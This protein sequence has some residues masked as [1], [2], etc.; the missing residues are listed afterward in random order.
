[1]A[2]VRRRGGLTPPEGIWDVYT[3]AAMLELRLL[4]CVV[5]Q[6]WK[7]IPG[8]KDTYHTKP[9]CLVSLPLDYLELDYCKLCWGWGQ[10]SRGLPGT[11]LIRT[12][13]RA[14]GEGCWALLS[15]QVFSF[16]VPISLDSN[17]FVKLK[18]AGYWRKHLLGISC[19]VQNGYL[20]PTCQTSVNLC[21]MMIFSPN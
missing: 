1:M 8:K 15:M 21:L 13:F 14:D 19:H 5:C 16:S 17:L 6:W 12:V 4:V 10:A 20:L 7:G 18:P 11:S 2:V 3:E 9:S